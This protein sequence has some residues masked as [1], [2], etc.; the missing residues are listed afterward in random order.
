MKKSILTST[1][2]LTTLAS[3]PAAE[4]TGTVKNKITHPQDG[5]FPIPKK[6]VKVLIPWQDR[7]YDPL[8]GQCFRGNLYRNG[9]L[10][11]PA[12][13]AKP[14]VK[15]TAEVGGKVRSS[16]VVTGGK[17]FVGGGGGFFCL[18]AESGKET[19][20][21]D[22]PKGVESSACISS[23]VAYIGGMDGQLYA[24]DAASG[25]VKWDSKVEQSNWYKG[26]TG[27]EP[28][29]GSAAVAYGA[30]FMPI[31]T[32]VTAFDEATGKVIWIY[33]ADL[34][35][36]TIKFKGGGVSE[37]AAVPV[38]EKGQLFLQS[39]S[40]WGQTVQVDVGSSLGTAPYFPLATDGGYYNTP[41]LSKED[42]LVCFVSSR[43]LYAF[44]IDNAKKPKFQPEVI[45]GVGTNE[46]RTNSSPAIWQGL[47]I[48]G[49]DTG[50][51]YAY[52]TGGK[53]AWEFKAGEKAIQSS[54]TVTSNG[55]VL[56]GCDDGHLYCVDGKTGKKEWEVKV[57]GQ[58][59][60]S[61]PW[62]DGGTIFVGADDGKIYSLQ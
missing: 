31:G 54:P 62:V 4:I 27:V 16:P 5:N 40:S 7:K 12:P 53:K 39:N 18:D 32:Q 36:T 60:R 6:E 33:N 23:G 50:I 59:V 38:N 28:A 26:K 52:D 11:S 48:W 29:K 19:W 49:T 21:L 42:N 55:K 9:I 13:L 17:V 51:L 41:A 15:W 30:V 20:K 45:F 22:I 43:R 37:W 61:T 25:K 58:P 1:L 56:F 14:A 34:G 44:D 46:F 24:V 3:M 47:V 2:L 10:T 35:V 57:S 8:Q